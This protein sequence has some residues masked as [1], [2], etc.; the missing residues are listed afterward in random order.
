MSMPSVAPA[1]HSRRLSASN[2]RRSEPALAPSAART[3]SSL[4]RRT[5]RARIKF[6]DVGAGDDEDE[7][8]RGEQD[9][10]HRAR[11]GGDLVAQ[12][13]GANAEVGFRGIGFGMALIIVPWTALSSA[14]A[15]SRVCAGS[16]AAE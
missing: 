5:V 14:R 9:P 6:A 12:E 16:E 7:S 11:A 13:D 10:Q 2:V 15:D 4:S 3:A 8:G 1:P